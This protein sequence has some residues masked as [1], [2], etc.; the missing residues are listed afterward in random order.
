MMKRKYLL[1]LSFA[2]TI[3]LLTG[4]GEKEDK[5]L[6]EARTAIA[7]NDYAA[8][9]N[10]VTA[11]VSG[12]PDLPEAQALQAILQ[13]RSGSGWKTGAGE[14]SSALQK[15]LGTLQPLNNEIETLRNHEDP[16]SDDLDRLE[17]HV[18]SRNSAA[19]FLAAA[20]AEATGS[21]GNLLADLV[22]SA[23]SVVITALLEAEKCFNPAH[24]Q[25]AG[26][27][28]KN[29][30]NTPAVT[31]LL[32]GATE[33]PDPEIRAHAVRHLGALKDP[34]LIGEFQSVL[35]KKEETPD[36]LYSAI[37]ALE[38]LKGPQIIPA[39]RTAT[40]ANA[41]AARMHAAK[42]LG[43]LKA[44]DAIPD[45]VHLLADSDSFVKDSASKALTA[46]REP[47]IAP[48]IRVVD[49]GA[50][51]VLPE[52]NP[53]FMAE[54]QYV[55]NVYIDAKRLRNRRISTQ[56]AAITVLG[57]LRAQ[58][59]IETLINLLDDDDL[60]K[61][62]AAALTAM[63]G[64]AVPHLIQA[65]SD[66]RDEI[67]IQV[68]AALKDIAD[69]RAIAPLTEALNDPQERKEVK[70]SAAEALGKMWARQPNRSGIEALTRALTLDDT[71]AANAGTALGII[72]DKTDSTV[73]RLIS[74][75]MDKRA[76]ETVRTAAI[77]AIAGVK[78]TQATQPM[79]LLMLSDET[80]P[81]IR[82]AAVTALGEIKAKEATPVLLWVLG[83]RYD[84]I[85]AF[86]RRLKK[87]YK[88]LDG[89]EDAIGALGV[90][91][92]GEHT[93]P[94]YRTW[95]EPKS[96]PSLVRAEVARALGK[97]KGDD[98]KQ[99]LIEALEED[100]R[101]AVRQ[102]V[103]W[104]LGEIKGD[105][106]I[107]PL[108]QAMKKDDRGVVRQEAAEALG[109]IKGDK[110]V[111]PLVMTLQKDKFET[112]RKKAA[113]ALRELKQEL[114]DKGMVDVLARGAGPFEENQEV[115]SI[116]N[117][118]IASL[119]KQGNQDTSKFIADALKSQ[120]EIKD[121]GDEW[122]RWKLVS[123]LGTLE[124][125]KKPFV[126]LLMAEAKHPSYPVRKAAVS[127]LGAYKD[128]QAFDLL[129]EILRDPD[130][131]KS[132]RAAAAS[133]LG[134]LLD[135]RAS[136]PLFVALEDK[137]AEVRA[138]AA[139]A[140][141]EIKEAKAVDKLMARVQDSFEDASVR[142]E[143]ITALGKI[144]DGRAEDLLIGVLDTET[145][146]LYKRAIDALGKLKGRKAIPKLIEILE[147]RGQDL[148]ASTEA[149][150]KVSARVRAAL[151]LGEIGDDPRSAEAIARVLADDTEYIVAIKDKL[152]RNWSWEKYVEAAKAFRLPPFVAA[153]LIERIDDP[154]ESQLLKAAATR[155]LGQCEGPVATA[156]LKALFTHAKHEIRQAAA[157]GAGRGQHNELTGY[158]VKIMKG[159]TETHKDVRRGATQGLGE[160]RD[161][162]TVPDLI[163]TLNNDANHVEIRQDAAIALGKIG[164]DAAVSALIEKLQALLAS[165]SVK[166]VRVNC[167]KG[168]GE[169]GS[170][171]AEAT[172][173]LALED[174]DSD[175]HFQA[176][177]A[178]S[179]LE[180]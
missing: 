133:S 18:R 24:R 84:D 107:D 79:L 82:K 173:K 22:G 112:A 104:S 36:V 169:A 167:I 150:A 156:K 113:I 157:L 88:T 147:D 25:T 177:L 21:N 58:E 71:T 140:L 139:K 172:L 90:E 49:S 76:R 100:E 81:A 97:I 23:N 11:A 73:S 143:S 51:S 29:L 176:A 159:E 148:D 28:V 2:L 161:A 47:S 166:A 144:E 164:D 46:I 93:M 33:H 78:P 127:A 44:A 160:M 121:I 38:Q 171:K 131:S 122:I 114:S 103:A 98:A 27:L 60:K 142:A 7:E 128:R 101:A 69:R 57:D 126:P 99:G 16:D 125:K 40:R 118:V 178:L 120:R 19:G 35:E 42:M 117:E 135:K 141:G 129:V 165:K 151:A 26:D 170:R 32:V 162:S 134:G 61:N 55:A 108:I 180:G 54:Y 34:S 94:T 124:H 102:G 123:T 136:E 31:D 154:W 75:A 43:Q 17:R 179:K 4:C 163:E 65:L 116:H 77:S 95:A 67:R 62:A 111:T 132:I 138:Q 85:K 149:L 1:L 168:L 109:K 153:K 41:A 59:A 115:E 72:K 92:T 86:Q 13:L 130:E 30:G 5:N 110:V 137:N 175:V 6:L 66:P 53:D 20:L 50:H 10:A 9:Q 56:A 64:A 91:W 80:S 158:L 87:Q 8:A 155:C 3:G 15:V 48:L 45:L 105:D 146:D 52:E 70:A 174:E 145:G 37:V 83:T 68:A 96:I 106:V 39:L 119:K 89:L 74:I 12:K 14:W 63:K 152:K